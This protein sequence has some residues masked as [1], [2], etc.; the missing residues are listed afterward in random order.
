MALQYGRCT[1]FGLCTKAD[2]KVLQT[3]PDGADFLCEECK[4]PLAG[5][6]AA[7]GGGGGGGAKAL[8]ILMGVV[9]LLVLGA[10]AS[11]YFSLR[12]KAPDTA[13]VAETAPAERRKVPPP[14]T[15][16]ITPLL[17]LSGSNTIGESL[18]PALVEGWLSSRGAT[19]LRREST[20]SDE[21]RVAG[22][23]DGQPVSVE[24]K[25][26]GS[27]TAFS[28]LGSEAADIGMASR[29]ITPQEAE[30]LKASRL[31]D[32]TS[33]ANERVIGLD[34]VAV[35][36]NEA[37]DIDTMSKSEVAAVFSGK[38][39]GREWHVYARDD[40]SGTFDTFQSQVLGS[41][42]LVSSAR[43]FEDSKALAQAVAQDPK[44]IGFLGLPYAV[45]VKKLA[46]SEKGAMAL[47]PTTMTVRTEAYPLDRRL[48]FYTPDNAK[49]AARQ[50]I[51]FAIST[52]GQEIVERN[53]FVGQKIEAM[54]AQAAPAN[55]PQGYSAL[56]TNGDRLSVDF[57]FRTGS[58]QL[59]TKAVDDINRVATS[60]DQQYRGRSVILVGFADN[61]G[62]PAANVTLS[63][64]R[65]QAVAGL[66]TSRGVSVASSIG[67][68]DAMPV[69]DN[70]TP[71]GREKNRRVEVW[72]RR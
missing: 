70:G 8:P 65:A 16:A 12:K 29:K 25:A 23:M 39:G 66:M 19:A 41:L 9:L 14:A 33:N 68:G 26:H 2:T 28:D 21:I 43:R 62:S 52:E 59:D 4:R 10:G 3:V 35:I 67:L 42:S 32:L 7:G 11:F 51:T 34:G 64:E 22:V 38:A 36:V 45:G 37:N 47:V 69:A 48:Y 31:G 49:P 63:K 27:K 17:R 40:K 60:L 5:A 1:N 61:T 46:I 13:S 53:G 18:A 55:A 30:Q 20:G 24:I 58:S 71:D 15:T 56:S 72:L 54:S 57:R 50:L 6:G 44:G